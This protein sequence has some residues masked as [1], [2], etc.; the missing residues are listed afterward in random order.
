MKLNRSI[1]QHGFTLGE[2]L[3]SVAIVTMLFAGVF[4]ATVALNRAYAAAD[5]YFATHVQQIRIMD[6]LARDVKRSYSVT[7]SSDL[8]TVTCVIPDYII[9]S[10]EPDAAN[11]AMIGYRRTPVVTGSIN[12]AVVDYGHRSFS[13]GITTASSTTLS[14]ATATCTAADVGKTITGTNIPQGTT[15]SSCSSGSSITLSQPATASSTGMNFSIIGDGNRTVI[16]AVTTNGSTSLTSASAKFTSADVGKAIVGAS[17]NAGTT[18]SSVSSGTTVT[19]SAAA[20]ATANNMYTSIGGIVVV[21]TVSGS[22]ITRT[23]N[24]QLTTIA[25]STDNLLPQTTDWQL[26]NTEYTTTTVTFQPIFT[27]GTS[28]AQQTM[29]KTGTTVYATAYLRNKRRGN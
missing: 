1:S 2:A 18:I 7:T 13:D 29:S 3:V 11:S 21:Y 8:K 9:D 15:I 26:S 24:G 16:D 22:K 17:I 19:L 6:Y 23:E 20:N 10:G 28:S 4:T 25:A 27:S 12:K 5:N 14:S